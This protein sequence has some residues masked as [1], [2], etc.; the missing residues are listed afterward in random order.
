MVRVYVDLQHFPGRYFQTTL[1]RALHILKLN[2]IT[3]GS[4]FVWKSVD[5]LFIL[6]LSISSKNIFPVAAKRFHCASLAYEY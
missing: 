4:M 2:F 5:T 6:K 3:L 1:D